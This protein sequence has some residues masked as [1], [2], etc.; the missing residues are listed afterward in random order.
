MH[1]GCVGVAHESAVA[2]GDDMALNRAVARTKLADPDDVIH[3]FDRL[4]EPALGDRPGVR[5]AETDEGRCPDAVYEEQTV[6][7]PDRAPRRGGRPLP[8]GPSRPGRA[9]CF[10]S[11]CTSQG[12]TSVPRPPA[13]QGSA[14]HHIEKLEQPS[15]SDR[16]TP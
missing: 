6:R 7:I 1:V 13:A 2:F 9:A 14:T 10:R 4:T 5:V 11:S 12:T 3:L 8:S 16:K 15:V